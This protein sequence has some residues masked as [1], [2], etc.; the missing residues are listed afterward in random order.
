MRERPAI[1]ANEPPAAKKKAPRSHRKD[2]EWLDKRTLAWLADE[3]EKG[4]PDVDKDIERLVKHAKRGEYES[5]R[6]YARAAEEQAV[7]WAMLNF[8]ASLRA[9]V[10][11]LTL[12][13]RG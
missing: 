5:A 2:P 12:K 3:I 11:P 13:E 4:L 10:K 1:P 8:V 9:I 6:M 7:R